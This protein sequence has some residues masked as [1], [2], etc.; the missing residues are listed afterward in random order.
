[1]NR[2]QAGCAAV[3]AVKHRARGK[4]HLADCLSSKERARLIRA[5]L[6]RVIDAAEAAQSIALTLVVSPE[7]DTIPQSIPV[8]LDEGVGLN[9]AFTLAR[10]TLHRMGVAAMLALSADLPSVDAVD[11][12]ALTAAASGSGVALAPDVRGTGT[13]ALVSPVDLPMRFQFGCDSRKLHTEEARRLGIE[14]SIVLRPGL[15]FDV[16]LP[17]DLARLGDL[18]SAGHRAV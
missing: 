18:E 6:G 1:M 17:A 3:I 2:S 5:M 8:L 15:A 7:R 9:E 12:D 14:L 13:N 4:S 16:D 10:A 11:L